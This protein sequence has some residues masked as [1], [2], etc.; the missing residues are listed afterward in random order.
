MTEDWKHIDDVFRSAASETKAPEFDPSYWKEF[1]QLL[2]TQN[3]KRRALIWSSSLG[4]VALV[5]LIVALITLNSVD[6]IYSMNYADLQKELSV[7]PDSFLEFSEARN[8]IQQP[9]TSATHSQLTGDAL[10]KTVDADN[11]KDTKAID[12]LALNNLSFDETTL[13]VHPATQLIG[14]INDNHLVFDLSPVKIG[15][16]KPTTSIDLFGGMGMGQAHNGKGYSPLMSVGIRG[17]K[18]W[19]KLGINVGLGIQKQLNPG[20]EISQRSMVYDFGVTNFENQ[21]SYHSFTEI[22]VPIELNY[23]TKAGKIGV[24]IQPRIMNQ[25]KMEYTALEN[26]IVSSSEMLYGRTVG[27]NVLDADLFLT[28]SKPI[29]AN[30]EIG[31]KVSQA[32]AGRVN[33]PE[34]F[35]QELN[36]RPLQAQVMLTY[37]LV[38]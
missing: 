7:S 30:L 27:I 8:N 6:G 2:D 14:G 18:V 26:N 31:M 36:N 11:F 9:L 19:N 38:K 23:Q 32:V 13:S 33:Q 5:G 24:G 37:N 35:S 17:E 21:L 34:L 15:K 10:Q 4:S 22:I 3:R 20:L 12:G 16:A 1:E 29:S 28:Y 25:S